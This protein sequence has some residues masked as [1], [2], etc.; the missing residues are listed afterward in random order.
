M[1]LGTITSLVHSYGYFALFLLVA[2]ESV[3]IPLPGE[4]ALITA[5]LYAGSTGNLNIAAVAVIAAAAAVLGDNVGYWLG[6]VG[7]QRFVARHGHRVGLDA[8]K[9]KVGR[10]LF[11]RHGVPVVLFGRFVSLLRTFA[12]FFAGVNRMPW[13]AFLAAKRCGWGALGRRLCLR[14]LRSR[15]RCGQRWVDDHLRRVGGDRRAD[16][17]DRAGRQTVDERAPA[18]CGGCVP[19]R[20]QPGRSLAWNRSSTDPAERDFLQTDEGMDRVYAYLSA[21]AARRSRP[22]SRTA[23]GSAAGQPWCADDLVHS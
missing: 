4:T 22:A 19:G 23:I 14:R 18:P 12:A 1:T 8:A 15:S 2:L 5:A 21:A 11:E 17:G 3:G 13:P 9:L 6:E 7:G 10:Y 16:A 20:R